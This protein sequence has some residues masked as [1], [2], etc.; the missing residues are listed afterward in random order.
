[1]QIYNTNHRILSIEPGLAGLT[2]EQLGVARS[3]VD[4]QKISLRESI[5]KLGLV[6]ET[7]LLMAAAQKSGLRFIDICPTDID[8]NALRAV[9]ANVASHYSIVPLKIDGNILQVATCDPFNQD[10][11]KELE[12]VLDNTH[13]IEL[14]LATSESI[15]KATRKC[16]GVG[17]ATVEQMV[18]GEQINDATTQKKDLV[19][20]SKVREASVIKLVNQLLADA[21]STGATDIHIEPYEDDLKVRYRIDGVLHDAGVP[22]TVRFFRDGIT[23][24]I[25]IISGLDIAEKRL[26]QD[27]RAQVDLSGHKF[28]LRISILPTRYGE[29]INVRILPQSTIIS[30]LPSLGLSESVVKNLRKLIFKPHGIILVTGPTGSGKTTTLY[31][32]MNILKDTDSKIITIEDPVEYDMPGIVQMQ[33]HPEIGFTFARALRS[34]LRHDPDIMLVGEIRDLE[35][36][37]TAI[38]TALTG[39]LVFSTLHTN[40]AASAITRLLDMGIEPYLMAS[41]VEAILAQRLVRVICPDCK[42]PHEPDPEIVTAIKSLARLDELPVVYHGRGCPK[43]RFS[44]YSG[45][46]AIAEL[47]LLSENIREMTI[48]KRH[49]SEIDA[50]ACR[51]GMT[52][53]F[54]SGLAKVHQGITTYE[55][56]LRA[57]KGMVMLD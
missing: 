51:E 50:Q 28:D 23:S 12:L 45:R 38:R 5:L 22:S 1:M 13:N 29:A 7:E 49:A 40:D 52:S 6:S 15:K 2:E 35:T 24:R 32:C 39:H 20:E 37:E 17:A 47:L 21:I 3:E 48:S 44:G 18:T 46:T 11:K 31:T 43:C 10:L 36:A 27:G 26:P 56:V 55:E 33:V 9:T 57:T 42:E 41:S 54:F 8:P 4:R 14:V 19:D 53:L 30:D 34:M 16:Y 25:K